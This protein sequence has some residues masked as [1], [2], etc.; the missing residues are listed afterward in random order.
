MNLEANL[1]FGNSGALVA[2]LVVY[3][4]TKRVAIM[5]LLLSRISASQRRISQDT[6]AAAEQKHA[7]AAGPAWR[8]NTGRR[9]TAKRRRSRDL[10]SR[11]IV[12]A[13]RSDRQHAGSEGTSRCNG[14][15]VGR[16]QGERGGA[17]PSCG[18]EG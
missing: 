7:P 3:L 13:R 2:L 9:Q 1:D 16:V 18:G 4:R 12:P 8:R 11:L 5:E 17:C 6:G 10:S 14:Q 15:E